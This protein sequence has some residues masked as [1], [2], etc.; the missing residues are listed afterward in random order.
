[1]KQILRPNTAE[2]ATKVVDGEAILIN[3]SN[4][5]YYS[6]DLVGGYIWSLIEAKHD[7]D[8][9]IGAVTR[10]YDVSETTARQDV[11]HLARQLLDEAIVISAESESSAGPVETGDLSSRAE[12]TAPLFNKFDDMVDLFA[13]DPPLPE[14]SKIKRVGDDGG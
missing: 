1:V 6:M 7:V 8:E 3:L 9:I 2:F 12:Y 13:L 14:L 5:M 10:R 11:E 4:G